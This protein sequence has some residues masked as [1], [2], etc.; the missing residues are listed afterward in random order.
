MLRH[1]YGHKNTL[2]GKTVISNYCTTT[3]NFFFYTLAFEIRKRYFLLQERVCAGGTGGVTARFP[4][5]DTFHTHCQTHTVRVTTHYDYV[6]SL[7]RHQHYTL[8]T[9]YILPDCVVRSACPP[10][11][12]GYY[13][14]WR[15]TFIYKTRTPLSVSDL[16]RNCCNND[17]TRS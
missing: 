17:V 12:Y 11:Y 3:S 15:H 1:C 16:G 5:N 2:M 6:P 8:D 7:P 10:T 4:V 13:N 9:A 14:V